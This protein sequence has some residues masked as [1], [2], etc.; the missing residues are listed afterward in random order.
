MAQRF[1]VGT[2][3]GLFEY[4]R[5]GSG[6]EI[7]ALHHLAQP[8]S[9]VLPLADGTLYAALTLGH[10]G[11]KLHRLEPGS[12]EWQELAVPAFPEGSTV[13][14][15]PPTGEGPP[16]TKP[17][18]LDEIWALEPGGADQPGLLWAGTIPGGLFRSTDRGDSWQL[19][20]S[21]WDRP[22]RDHWFG[23]G[24]DSPGIHSISV[25]P[26]DSSNVAVSVSCGGVWKT[27]DSG[28]TWSCDATGLRADYMPPE[29]ADNPVAQDPHRVVQCPGAPDTLWMQHHNGV[30]L[31]RDRGYSWE[32]L[33]TP[34]PAV[35]GFAV[36]VHPHDPDTAWL[37]PATKDEIR[38]PVDA[39]VVV[40]RTRDGGKS[41]EVL[42]QG[43]PQR[44][45]Y[46]IVYRHALDIDAT[47]NTLAFGSTTGG[48]WLSEDQGDHWQC[49]S[50][51]LPP[52]Y[53]VRFA[54]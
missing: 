14:D 35:F 51:N 19:I 15:G 6:W 40:S 34:Q 18:S 32:E 49:L 41:F 27:H 43:L 26:R 20:E 2:R 29:M 39:R 37:V 24:K 7:S 28:A 47:G 33:T 36:A 1:F 30:F 54:E 42:D 16:Q 4:S 21:L 46:D 9:I 3:K 17:A 53:C 10:F 8:V 5:N 12:Q 23:G 45:A 52:V 25:D 13:N 22:E 44:D 31:S 48:L 11:A 38:V 50:Q